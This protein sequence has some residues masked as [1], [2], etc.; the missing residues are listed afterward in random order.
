MDELLTRV[1]RERCLFDALQEAGV[2]YA[3]LGTRLREIDPNKID[4]AMKKLQEQFTVEF[5]RD[6]RTTIYTLVTALSAAVSKQPGNSH[7]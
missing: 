5:K 3:T 7:R 4:R 6:P 2:D 1:E